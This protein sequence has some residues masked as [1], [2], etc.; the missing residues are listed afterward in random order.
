ML[1]AFD[2]GNTNIVLGCFDNDQLVQEFRIK[3]DISRTADEY[4]AMLISLLG[5]K[6]GKD[7]RFDG[8]IISSVVPPL[9][10]PF[11]ELIK[12]E[13]NLDALIVSNK[14]N[15]SGIELKVGKPETLGADRIV[16]IVAAK[17]DYGMPSLVVDFGTATTFEFIDSKN[18]YHSG[19]IIPGLNICL[20]A[21]ISKTAQLPKIEKKFPN[22]VLATD[23]ITAIQAGTLV[24][25][26]CLIRG[27]IEYT[28]KEAGEDIE[29]IIFTG[30]LGRIF[31]ERI[32]EVTKNDKKIGKSKQI[33]YD[34]GL[35]LRGIYYVWKLNQ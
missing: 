7:V 33:I 5:A 6:F 29:H 16:D 26:E 25:Y 23:T 8:A 24:G 14:L 22:T 1:L 27:L 13:F 20:D 15:I 32:N 4:R 17:F 9:T 18:C 2:I 35:T 31:S 30:G 12:T 34:G 19:A 10:A 21:L 3:T 28:E 11:S